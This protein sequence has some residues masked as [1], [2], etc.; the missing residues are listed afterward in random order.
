MIV[1]CFLP[2]ILGQK[3]ICT[4]G[5]SGT[6]ECITRCISTGFR[7]GICK[8]NQFGQ[9]FCCCYP[10]FKSSDYFPVSNPA[11]Y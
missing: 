6:P 3:S 4:I 2:M 1:L 9:S 10:K 11:D 8:R 5:C 7:S